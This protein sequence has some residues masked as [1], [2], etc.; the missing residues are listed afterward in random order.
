MCYVEKRVSKDEEKTVR[1]LL[2]LMQ[3]SEKQRCSIPPL[4][5]LLGPLLPGAA[6]MVRRSKDLV[7]QAH[8]GEHS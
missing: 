4:S 7:A 2:E 5:P 8:E 6:S 1:R 3:L